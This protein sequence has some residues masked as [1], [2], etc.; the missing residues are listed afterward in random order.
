MNLNSEI[1]VSTVTASKRRLGSGSHTRRAVRVVLWK[2]HLGLE[3]STIVNRV[4][5][6]DDEGDMPGEDVLVNE[7]EATILVSQ[8]HSAI[9]RERHTSM[10]VQGSL[11]RALNS[12]IR[13]LSAM[14]CDDVEGLSVSVMPDCGEDGRRAS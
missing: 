11:E 5:V 14:M 2:C 9:A 13:I 7:L 1:L 4:R 12:D 10:L 6:D 8:S 3:E